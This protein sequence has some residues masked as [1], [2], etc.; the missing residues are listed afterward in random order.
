MKKF[1]SLLLAFCLTTGI[2]ASSVTVKAESTESEENAETV[3]DYGNVDFWRLILKENIGV[4]FEMSFADAIREDSEAYVEI[5]VA[6]ETTQVPLDAA[7]DGLRV[8]VAAAQ[9][10]DPIGIS[11]VSGEGI[12]DE[13]GVYSVKAYGDQIINGDYDDATK[14]LVKSMLTYGAMAQAYFQYHLDTPANA[15]V[16]FSLLD[17]PAA[18]ETAVSVSD[19]IEG[20][21]FYGASLCYENNLSLRYYFE[22]DSAVDYVFSI[23]GIQLQSVEKDG[24]CYVE[25]PQILPQELSDYFSI[26]VTDV[27]GNT[28]DVVYSPADYV[29]RMFYKEDATSETKDLLQALYTYCVIASAYIA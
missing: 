19:A 13:V 10:A 17:M 12:R 15:N 2:L 8:N 16:N 6:E 27:Q 25:I 14:K 3:V 1:L 20:L 23:N 21:D 29:V 18:E 7:V 28:V 4:Y 5:T 22:T 9:M 11:I 26:V 24:L